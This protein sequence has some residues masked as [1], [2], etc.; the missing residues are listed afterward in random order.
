MCRDASRGPLKADTTYRGPAKAGHYVLSVITV[1]L[2]PDTTYCRSAMP[3]FAER[4]K[5]FL[6]RPSIGARVG[7]WIEPADPHALRIAE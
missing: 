4:R 3:G 7:V 2:K 6:R 1:R 5:D